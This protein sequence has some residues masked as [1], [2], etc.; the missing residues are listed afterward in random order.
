MPKLRTVIWCMKLGNE[1]LYG[2]IYQQD[3]SD[4]LESAR[5]SDFGVPYD[6][7]DSC[8]K[9]KENGSQTGVVTIF[10]L[11]TDIVSSKVETRE[12]NKFAKMI[13]ES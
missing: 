4:P 9:R 13:G 10:S 11:L 6:P 7:N 3:H 12:K 1:N 8:T 5:S 2:V